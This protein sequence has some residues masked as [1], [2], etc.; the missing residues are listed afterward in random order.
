ME[1]KWIE[2]KF[3]SESK[4]VYSMDLSLS[5]KKFYF[6]NDVD[7]YHYVGRVVD[8]QHGDLVIHDFNFIKS[9]KKYPISKCRYYNMDGKTVLVFNIANPLPIQPEYTMKYRYWY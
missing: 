1:E 6:Y 2:L 5:N 8:I 7:G 3:E 9:R 4:E